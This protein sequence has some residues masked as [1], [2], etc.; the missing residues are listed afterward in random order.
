MGISGHMLY[1]R[2]QNPH[3]IND[4]QSKHFT[5]V[6]FNAM[7]SNGGHAWVGKSLLQLHLPH[8]LQFTVVN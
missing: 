5:A 2:D 1:V 6:K 7:I 4:F 3:A 8:G